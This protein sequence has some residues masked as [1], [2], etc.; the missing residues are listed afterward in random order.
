VFTDIAADYLTLLSEKLGVEWNIVFDIPFN[1]ALERANDVFIQQWQHMRQTRSS[2]PP[3]ALSSD[4]EWKSTLKNIEEMAR[5]VLGNASYLRRSL[6]AV[7][8]FLSSAASGPIARW[9]YLDNSV[10]LEL[11]YQVV[12]FR[13]KDPDLLS[14]RV[15]NLGPGPGALLSYPFPVDGIEQPAGQIFS[16]TAHRFPEFGHDGIT[17]VNCNDSGRPLLGTAIVIAVSGHDLALEKQASDIMIP[18]E[19][20]TLLTGDAAGHD[21]H[22]HDQEQQL[23][24]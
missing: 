9:I 8:V 4:Q 2:Q 14:L 19:R 17:R 3:E 21:K 22:E 23:Q 18:P 5:K 6:P 12:V 20:T 10:T 16:F 24:H 11:G 1:K 13:E 7:I 15:K